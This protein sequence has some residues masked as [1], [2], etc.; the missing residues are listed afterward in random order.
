[1]LISELDPHVIYAPSRVDFHPE[2]QRVAAVLAAVLDAAASRHRTVR[3]YQVQVPLTR[4]LGNVVAPIG[5]LFP[6]VLRAAECYGSQ[7]GSLRAPIRL[8]RYA[9][10]AYRLPGAAEVFWEMTAA[11]YAGMQRLPLSTAQFHALRRPALGDPLGFLLGRAER[12]R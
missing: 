12:R 11:E 10:C 3:V 7:E 8:K 1:R 2:H 5:A 6:T 4:I 9:A